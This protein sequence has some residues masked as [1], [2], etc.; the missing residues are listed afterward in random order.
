M[1][2]CFFCTH[3]VDPSFKDL[4][5]LTKFLTPRRKIV[6]AAKSMV[7]AKHQR[8]LAVQVKYARYLALVPYTSYQTEAV[9]QKI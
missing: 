2:K 7:C 5:N 1:T 6:D 4:E 8:K 9:A 3:K